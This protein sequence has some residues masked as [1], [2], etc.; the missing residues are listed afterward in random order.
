MFVSHLSRSNVRSVREFWKLF[1]HLKEIPV[2]SPNQLKWKQ[3]INLLIGSARSDRSLMDSIDPP[4]LLRIADHFSAVPCQLRRH[5][6]FR[7]ISQTLNSVDSRIRDLSTGQITAVLH[8]YMDA[9]VDVVDSETKR[10]KSTQLRECITETH[11]LISKLMAEVLSRD[12]APAESMKLFYLIAK[13]H[14]KGW[15]ETQSADYKLQNMLLDTANYLK[16]AEV[17]FPSRCQTLWAVGRLTSMEQITVPENIRTILRRSIAP[18]EFV[19]FDI[20]SNYTAVQPASKCEF[21]HLL[22]LE[23]FLTILDFSDTI[24]GKELESVIEKVSLENI[25]PTIAANFIWWSAQSE[26][27]IHNFLTDWMTTCASH[28]NLLSENDRWKAVN[29][30]AHIIEISNRNGTIKELSEDQRA[31]VNYLI[32]TVGKSFIR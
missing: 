27:G 24:L 3:A 17:D 23:E 9:S 16:T 11:A 29:G 12:L 19:R 18:T 10:F 2:K 4:D 26:S 25:D 31:R 14:S 21:P 28:M 1:D 6:V 15:L 7:S 5:E 8:S 32:R 22:Q 13:G 20:S 30:F